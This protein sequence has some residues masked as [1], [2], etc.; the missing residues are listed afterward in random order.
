MSAALSSIDLIDI[1]NAA[2]RAA[3]EATAARW[4][5]A[6]GGNPITAR[7]RMDELTTAVRDQ[8]ARLGFDLVERKP[9]HPVRE[10]A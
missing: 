4:I 10:A 5:V 9:A 2:Q 1:T 3:E 8:A 6:A 7:N